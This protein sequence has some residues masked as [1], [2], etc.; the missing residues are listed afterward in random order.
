[1]KRLGEE[2]PRHQRAQLP[3]SCALVDV[4]HFKRVNDTFGHPTGDE[5]LK[6]VAQ[7]LIRGLRAYDLVGRYG[8]EEF[9]VILPGADI[10]DAK[11]VCERLRTG[12]AERIHAGVTD[13]WGVTVSIGCA[14]LF[15]FDTQDLLVHR[16]DEALYEAKQCGR[17]CVVARAAS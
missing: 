11:T 16:A 13:G 17:N 12:V 9:L 8:G 4:D 1:M 6:Q 14:T 3:L 15:E 10:S 2:I 7:S 5:V